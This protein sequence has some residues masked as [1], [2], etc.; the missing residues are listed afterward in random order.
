MR[1]FFFLIFFSW[2]FLPPAICL[3]T[4]NTQSIGKFAALVLTWSPPHHGFPSEDTVVSR[5]H[6]YYPFSEQA[7]ET[8]TPSTHLSMCLGQP[9]I[10]QETPNTDTIYLRPH[11]FSSSE[12]PCSPLWTFQPSLVTGT[13]EVVFHLYPGQ[14]FF[15]CLETISQLWP[16]STWRIYQLTGKLPP[17]LFQQGLK[18]NL[19][20]R[21]LPNLF[22]LGYSPSPL[23]YF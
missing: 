19:G 13:L 21:L 2:L 20:K 8:S 22:F 5:P 1:V 23:G 4:Q 14:I 16:S 11:T 9:E 10:C 15:V 7:P 12:K 18:T 17:Y 6:S 3:Q